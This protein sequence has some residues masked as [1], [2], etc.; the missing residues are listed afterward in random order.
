MTRK[1]ISTYIEKLNIKSL[2]IIFITFGTL[3]QIYANVKKKEVPKKATI[4]QIMDPGHPGDIVLLTG[5]WPISLNSQSSGVE[6]EISQLTNNDA[7]SKASSSRIW[8]RIRPLQVSSQS[9]KF[10]IPENWPMGAYACRVVPL[11]DSNSFQSSETLFINAPDPWWIQGDGGATSSSPGGWLRIFG[12]GLNFDKKSQIKLDYLGKS[13][14]FSPTLNDKGGYTLSL[15]LPQDLPI[16]DYTVSIHNGFGGKETWKIAGHI[17][18]DVLKHWKQDLFN[19][20]KFTKGGNLIIADW[21]DAIKAAFAA[22]KANGGGVV[23]F[24]RGR[25]IVNEELK[26]PEFITLKGEEES[27]VNLYWPSHDQPLPNL[28]SGLDNFAIENISLYTDGNHKNVISGRH[29][30]RI[31]NVRIRANA[32]YRKSS[33]NNS[34]NPPLATGSAISISGNNSIIT[35]CDIYHS[36]SAIDLYNTNGG[37]IAHNI[38]NYGNGPMQVYGISRVIIEDNECKGAAL[39]SSGIGIS[40]NHWANASYHVYF[41]NNHISQTYGGSREAVTTDGHG[42]AYFGKIASTQNT[43]ITLAEASW[44]DTGTKDMIRVSDFKQGIVLKRPDSKS[45]F[46][47]E[48]W[49]GISMYIISGKGAGQYR[50]ILSFIGKEVNIESPWDIIPDST[51]IVSIGKFMGKMLF[52]GNEFRDAGTSIQLYPP[53]YECIVA[54]NQSWRT[55]SM[56]CGANLN[57]TSLKVAQESGKGTR[58]SRVEPSWYNQFLDNHF[59]EGNSWGNGSSVLSISSNRQTDGIEAHESVDLPIS[60]GHIIRGNYLDNNTNINVGVNVRNI[61]IEKNKIQNVEQGIII[62]GKTKTLV[63]SRSIPSVKTSD[64]ILIGNNTFLNVTEKIQS[65]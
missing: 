55:Q 48:E 57:F 45:F 19:V 41:A 51:S 14:F 58:M 39:W 7:N 28:I 53:N 21:S 36:S 13:R 11:N 46:S 44:W 49:H 54:E 15:N 64:D 35:H 3:Q 25:Y 50:N 62:K 29:N 38:L 31:Q 17:R 59:W 27:L 52:I 8:Q 4:I 20:T 18:I 5:D 26:I 6:V 23:F 65:P 47:G 9:L 24:P 37:I 16:G 43:R 34:V 63:N 12:K 42:T 1:Y 61:V 32:Y 30:I 10:V 22:A 56:N 40:L 2:L 60:M 33:I